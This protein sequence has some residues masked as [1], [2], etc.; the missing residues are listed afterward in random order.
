MTKSNKI[1]PWIEAL[2]WWDEFDYKELDKVAQSM[3]AQC[4]SCKKEKFKLTK[5]I[6]VPDLHA[7]RPVI[8]QLMSDGEIPK[9]DNLSQYSWD[10]CEVGYTCEKYKKKHP[11][12]VP[13]YWLPL[14]RAGL[15]HF[16]ALPSEPKGGGVIVA[17]IRP[18]VWKDDRGRPHRE[19]GPALQY[20]PGSASNEWWLHG[21]QVKQRYAEAP[22]NE[23]TPDEIL[24]EKNIDIRRELIRRVGVERLMDRLNPKMIDYEKVRIPEF[25]MHGKHIPARE[26]PYWLIEVQIG[27]ITIP[28][29]RYL[30]MLSPSLSTPDEPVWHVE[31]VPRETKTVR[32][33]LAF[34]NG[35]NK[36]PQQ[37]T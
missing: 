33:A 4:P 37:L 36:L 22:I 27:G 16:F 3:V 30:K 9:I 28:P 32:E 26:E 29:R 21:I 13:S 20:R 12:S 23:L 7:I 34:R 6:T 18:K 19:G 5:W 31:G 14:C 24:G 25:R 15:G 17:T 35:S 8:Q 1:D 11:W 10:H 2:S